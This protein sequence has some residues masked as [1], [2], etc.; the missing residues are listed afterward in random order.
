MIP[1]SHIIEWKTL[2]APWNSMAQVE[3]DLILERLLVELYNDELIAK[4]LAFR[5]GTALGKLFTE[6]P[7]RY[8]EDLDFVQ[9]HQ[10]PIG[11][12][13]SRIRK[14]VDPILGK[15][16]WK[17]TEG[18]VTFYY[19]FLSEV[20]PIINMRIKLEINTRDHFTQFGYQSFP[21]EVNSSWFTG[22]TTI[23]TYLL[24][25]LL[26]SKLKALYQRK[27]GRD[28]FDMLY[29]MTN[30]PNIDWEKVV[31]AFEN[32]TKHEGQNVTRAIFEKNLYAKLASEDYINDMNS[33]AENVSH[34][35][36]H[37]E[38]M[39]EV[40]TPLMRGESYCLVEGQSV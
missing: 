35:M 14:I 5:G 7:Y 25:E 21:F 17:Q 22:K 34:I 6:K 27:K 15:P 29:F 8:S 31:Q 26:G 10:E 3:Q 39:L 2:R 40:I 28:L 1:L 4:S 12:V 18:R 32:F 38:R 37:K 30:N 36:T 13:M 23:S 33:L 9:I 19:R 24:E 16:Q 11:E 20:E